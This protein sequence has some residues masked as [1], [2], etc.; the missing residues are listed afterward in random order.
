MSMKQHCCK[1]LLHWSVSELTAKMDKLQKS[2]VTEENRRDVRV[3]KITVEKAVL[4]LLVFYKCNVSLGTREDLLHESINSWCETVAA[5]PLSGCSI[6]HDGCWLHL[7][8]GPR[9][10]VCVFA[11]PQ[12]IW[13]GSIDDEGSKVS[14]GFSEWVCDT[15]GW[16][17]DG[18]HVFHHV[19]WIPDIL[20]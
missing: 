2:T 3:E 12:E 16:W 4:R 20:K 17:G 6:F 8:A 9:G 7:W 19:G 14:G 18:D 13:R 1:L 15:E 5:P 10:H 11:Y